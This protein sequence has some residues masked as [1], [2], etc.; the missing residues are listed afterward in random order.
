MKL[1]IS[2]CLFALQM[3]GIMSLPLCVPS[4][5]D[6]PCETKGNFFQVDCMEKLK[7][8]NS[9]ASCFMNSNEEFIILALNNQGRDKR[10]LPTEDPENY[11]CPY[12]GR[13]EIHRVRRDAVTEDELR[14]DVLSAKDLTDMMNKQNEIAT[15]SPVEEITAT[16]SETQ[17]GESNDGHIVGIIFVITGVSDDEENN[18][19]TPDMNETSPSVHTDDDLAETLV[20]LFLLGAILDELKK[21]QFADRNLEEEDDD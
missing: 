20:G 10:S 18:E 11:Q 21:T 14:A 3:S 19:I 8:K 12:K 4:A 15:E 1:T 2:L 13:V 7:F 5:D 17:D 6:V 9:K 16:P